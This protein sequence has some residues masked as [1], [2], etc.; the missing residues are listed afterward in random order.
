[1]L[2]VKESITSRKLGSRVETISKNSN[3]FFFQLGFTSCKAEQTPR[4]KELKKKEEEK[5]EENIGKL[6][7]KSP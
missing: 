5:D 6:L 4:I 1:M 7:R 2:M 3:L